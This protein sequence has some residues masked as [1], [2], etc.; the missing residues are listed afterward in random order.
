MQ[1]NP[2]LHGLYHSEVVPPGLSTCK[3]GTYSCHL[4]RLVLQPPPSILSA[5]VR[6]SAP[7]TGLDE[8]FFFSS[9]VVGPPYGSIFW[10]FWLFFCF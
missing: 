9:L 7:P 5:Q 4:T 2:G 6:I 10:Q 3:C 1:W 8:Y